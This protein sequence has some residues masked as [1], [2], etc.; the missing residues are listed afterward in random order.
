M[1]RRRSLALIGIAL[2]VLVSTALVA[3]AH[4]GLYKGRFLPNDDLLARVDVWVEAATICN[5][6]PT[7]ARLRN[8]MTAWNDVGTTLWFNW[9]GATSSIPRSCTNRLRN[10]NLVYRAGID[11]ADGWL[12]TLTVCYEDD[13]TAIHSWALRVDSAESWYT[14]TGTPSPDQHDW[15]S[16]ATHELGH[17]TGW[18][19]HLTDVGDVVVTNTE[20]DVGKVGG[21]KLCPLH[22]M[23]GTNEKGETYKRTLETHDKDTFI[24]VYGVFT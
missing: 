7:T 19:T 21:T 18:K 2:L 4:T 11:K 23:C 3:S 20:T 10:R 24:G 15:W 8:A 5:S 22:T 16:V 9:K 14:A 1:L 6:C 13:Q 12:A 17:G